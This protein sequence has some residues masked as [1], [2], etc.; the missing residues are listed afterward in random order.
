LHSC[1]HAQVNRARVVGLHELLRAAGVVGVNTSITGEAATRMQCFNDGRIRHRESFLRRHFLQDEGLLCTSV[2]GALVVVRLFNACPNH[3]R[4]TR[5]CWSNEG[6][7][8]RRAGLAKARPHR[9][10]M[11]F[12][13]FL[14]RSKRGVDSLLCDRAVP[15]TTHRA[16][17]ARRGAAWSGYAAVVGRP[18]GA[19]ARR[20]GDEAAEVRLVM[21]RSNA[22]RV[23]GRR[24]H[25][26]GTN[27]VTGLFCC[28]GIQAR[29][30]D[31][32]ESALVH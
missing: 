26:N 15:R 12:L 4:T 22:L 29:A 1:H 11:R 13:S 5:T 14:L 27:P 16:G 32:N 6:G 18:V 30:Y 31:L 9:E 17:H 23:L 2:L 8:S 24:A 7:P 28:T 3:F 21:N 25:G 10:S 19:D 20:G